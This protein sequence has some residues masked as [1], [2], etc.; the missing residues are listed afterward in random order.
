MAPKSVFAPSTPKSRT[1]SYRERGDGLSICE[2]SA[3][4]F[5]NRPFVVELDAPFQRLGDGATPFKGLQSPLGGF[6]LSFGDSEMVVAIDASDLQHFVGSFDGS[7]EF[8]SQ[9]ASL[10]GNVARFQRAGQGPRQSPAGS[11]HD[12]VQRGRPLLGGLHAVKILHAAV[13]TKQ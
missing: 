9:L 10:G 4:L 7:L 2:I 6:S 3:F 12:V 1:S 8:G 11:G 5:F 13:D